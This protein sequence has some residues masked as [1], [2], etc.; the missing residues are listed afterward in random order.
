MLMNMGKKMLAFDEDVHSSFLRNA[1]RPLKLC[2]VHMEYREKYLRYVRLLTVLL[3][4]IGIR[5][6]KF[7]YINVS[8][9]ILLLS[10]CF[11]IDDNGRNARS[12]DF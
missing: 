7:K 1:T 4:T 9:V 11:I 8:S 5:E 6:Y 10:F 3:E 2:G 12:T